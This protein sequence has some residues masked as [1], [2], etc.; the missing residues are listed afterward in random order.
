MDLTGGAP[1][2]HPDFRWLVEEIRALGHQV[3]DRCNL[4]VIRTGGNADLPE[5]FARHR[6]EVV[7]V[8]SL[9]H[10]RA[11]PR[12]SMPRLYVADHP[13]PFVSGCGI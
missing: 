7:V 10:H 6:V 3:I 12:P 5:F 13:V 1:E 4:T 11:T 8:A 2:L 9:P